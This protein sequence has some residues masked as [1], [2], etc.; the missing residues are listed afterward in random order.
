MKAE[1]QEA[2]ER[3]I[4]RTRTQL[5]LTITAL[6]RKLAARQLVEKG[7]DM[8][9]DSLGTDDPLNRSVEILRANLLPIALIGIGG[10][11]LAAANSGVAERI[12]RDERIEEA[13]R[14]V[15]EMAGNIGTRAG[16]LASTVAE[17]VGFGSGPEA[18]GHTGNPMID[19]TG[20][21]PGSDGWVH[22]ATDAAQDAYR[23]ARDRGSAMLNR[24]GNYAG[25]GASRVADQIADAFDRHPLLIGAI[26]VMAGAALAAL[27]PASRIEDEWFGA[28]RDR[29]LDQA[30]QAGQEALSR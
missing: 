20:A 13:R 3:G 16:E 11:W 5:D 26:G 17:R 30:G 19:E 25:D 24:A 6:E 29:L 14:R 8:F 23:T 2:I 27:L 12:A 7:F 15:S 9:R 10:A 1:S 22:Q 28:T 4:G 21:R 18:L